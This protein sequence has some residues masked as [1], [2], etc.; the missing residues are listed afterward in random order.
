MRNLYLDAANAGRYLE[1]EDANSVIDV[2]DLLQEDGMKRLC[3][4]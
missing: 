3:M 1:T 4:P 2:V